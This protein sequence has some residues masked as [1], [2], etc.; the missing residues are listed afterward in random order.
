[1]IKLSAR[2]VIKMTARVVEH[3]QSDTR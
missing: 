2:Y 3:R 1:V